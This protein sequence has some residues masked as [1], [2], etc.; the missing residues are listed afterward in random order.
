MP[1]VLDNSQR[2]R[3][4]ILIQWV[5]IGIS[6]L[7]L[8][9]EVV[10]Y[11]LLGRIA[12]G[13]ELPP[14]WGSTAD[15]VH[16]G[17]NN[18]KLVLIIMALIGLALW[19][20]RAYENLHR[21]NRTP[22]PRHSEG[23]GGWGWFVPILSFWF[24]YQ[25]MKD[26]WYLTQ[27]YSHS[28]EGSAIQLDNGF[29]G[30]WWALR[31]IIIFVSRGMSFPSGGTMEQLQH[32]VVFSGAMDALSIWYA[33]T[34]INLLKKLGRFEEALAAHFGNDGAESMP[35]ELPITPTPIWYGPV[36]GPK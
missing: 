23:A 10:Q 35:I 6:L 17:I 21:V 22:R 36:D 7:S 27:R 3:H 14:E 15:S 2:R 31:I 30:G 12:A 16:E 24:P 28:D 33:L 29:I 32:Y 9:S 4:A 13:A 34:V 19:T 5:V 11:V 8:L 20:Y 26:I 18:T 1:I 25:V